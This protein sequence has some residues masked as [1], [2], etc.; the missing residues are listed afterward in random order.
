MR[1]EINGKKPSL[2]ETAYIAPGARVIG[3]VVMAASSSIWFNAVVRADDNRISIGPDSNIQD[4]AVLHVDANHPMSIGAGVTVGHGAILHGCTIEDG[5]LIGMGAVVLDGAIIEK[6]SLIAAGALV[7][8]DKRIPAGSLVAGV[9]GKVIR[10]LAAKDS[11]FM[12]F[13]ARV[14]HDRGNAYRELKA[15]DRAGE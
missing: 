15:L 9:P 6:G 13:S 11:E 3:D 12:A 5:V 1:Y 8:Q 10:A 7:L 14:Y 4:N 2:H